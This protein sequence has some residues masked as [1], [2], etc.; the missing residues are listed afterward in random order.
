MTERKRTAG[1]AR[2]ASEANA[3][4][5]SGSEAET[6][7][8]SGGATGWARAAELAEPERASHSAAPRGIWWTYSLCKLEVI[9]HYRSNYGVQ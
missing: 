4:T 3:T 5:Q 8:E 1:L 2:R 7:A 9:R 6:R